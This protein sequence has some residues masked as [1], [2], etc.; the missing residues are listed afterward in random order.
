MT[1]TPNPP[2]PNSGNPATFNEDADAF[3]G[4]LATFAAQ[5][6]AQGYPDLPARFRI[7]GTA[8][9]PA[10]TWNDDPDTG[11]FRPGPNQ[12][13]I[14]A[15]GA[16]R[17][18]F[19]AAEAQI[20]VP[21]T[22]T[23][24]QSST[25]DKTAG[26]LLKVGAFGLGAPGETIGNASVTDNSIAPGC[27]G[28]G[29]SVGSTGGPSGQT[30][31][32]LIHARRTTGGGEAQLFIADGSAVAIFARSRGNGAWTPWIRLDPIRGSNSNG[33]FVRFGDGTQICMISSLDL[34][35]FSNVILEGTWTFPASFAQTPTSILANLIYT[36]PQPSGAHFH[37]TSGPVTISASASSVKARI[38]RLNAQANL[39]ASDR[40]PVSMMAIGRWF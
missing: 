30:W 10:L 23:A 19:T 31:G 3:F 7:N 16:M 38:Y 24:V 13:G 32:N 22:G 36:P 28:Y 15:G 11:I 35:Y 2:P 6:N 33:E 17:A 14:A 39:G 34:T 21:V 1:F 29:T 9:A 18:L 40:F 26:R 37:T 27:Y 8:L 12:L 5:L 20:N 25:T 4:W